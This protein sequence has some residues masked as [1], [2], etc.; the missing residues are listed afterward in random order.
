MQRRVKLGNGQLEVHQEQ[1]ADRTV[2]S[3]TVFRTPQ[4]ADDWFATPDPIGDAI[5]TVLFAHIVQS[6]TAQLTVLPHDVGPEWVPDETGNPVEIR[7]VDVLLDL[8]ANS[9]R[10]QFMS[11]LQ[12]PHVTS[13]MAFI[14]Q[15]R[16]VDHRRRLAEIM[17]HHF[18][19][20]PGAPTKAA[21]KRV[22]VQTA[23]RVTELGTKL[24][25]V[26]DFVISCRERGAD[27]PDLLERRL[28]ELPGVERKWAKHLARTRTTLK[29]AVCRI[30]AEERNSSV[31]AVKKAAERGWPLRRTT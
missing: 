25:A 23:E 8:L 10:D 16:S 17:R 31:K 6:L 24:E 20:P 28:I 3:T 12:A 11:L 19:A 5:D 30:V 7:N 18:P 15:G 9:T 1:H 2:V 14:Q 13:G 29:E 22:D 26:F 27:D 4:N 21:E